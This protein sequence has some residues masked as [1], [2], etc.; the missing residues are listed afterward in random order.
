MHF[1][2]KPDLKCGSK[3]NRSLTGPKHVSQ[4]LF[5]LSIDQLKR[6]FEMGSIGYLRTMQAYYSYRKT[7]GEDHVINFGSLA[8]VSGLVG[9]GPATYNMIKEGVHALNG[10]LRESSPPARSR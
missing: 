3:T 7:S 4:D 5:V 9:Y 2:D 6:N 8:G 10:P 1:P